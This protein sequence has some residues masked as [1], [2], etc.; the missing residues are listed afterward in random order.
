M[1]SGSTSFGVGYPTTL[2]A[3]QLNYANASGGTDVAITK[4]DTS[5]TIRIYST[6]LGGTK[7][8]LPHSMIVNSADELFIFG[9]TGSGDFPTTNSSFQPNFNGGP[10][11]SP[12]GIGVS[13]P[14][15]SDIF[16]SS[17]N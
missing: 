4:Y 13:F 2:G 16:V 8:E 9:T 7:D 11:F 14:D 10:G 12:S 15:G 6:Y 5:G 1:Y 17:K 3:Y